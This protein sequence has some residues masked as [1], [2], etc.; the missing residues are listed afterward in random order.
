MG[1]VFELVR[2]ILKA[3]Q[4]SPRP[5]K[6]GSCDASTCRMRR[7]AVIGSRVTSPALAMGL[8]H[9]ESL[10]TIFLFAVLHNVSRCRLVAG[11]WEIGARRRSPRQRPC[12]LLLVFETLVLHPSVTHHFHEAFWGRCVTTSRLDLGSVS[13]HNRVKVSH[14][15]R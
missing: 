4:R 11:S 7:S 6:S 10:P 1:E 5:G 9:A 14:P 2:C 13:V 8:R 3:P 15:P 12:F